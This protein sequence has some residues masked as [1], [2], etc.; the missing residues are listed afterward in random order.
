VRR[1]VNKQFDAEQARDYLIRHRLMA[2][3]R[4]D[5]FLQFAEKE[6]SYVINYN[7]GQDL[8]RGFVTRAAA[9]GEPSDTWARFEALLS[10]P[11]LPGDLL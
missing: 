2:P 1:L 4:A 9:P 3:E 8:V 6:R 7:L 11:R 5:K 10:S